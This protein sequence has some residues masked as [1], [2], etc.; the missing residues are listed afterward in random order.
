MAEKCLDSCFHRNNSKD[1]YRRRKSEIEESWLVK[2]KENLSLIKNTCSHKQNVGSSGSIVSS[3][4]KSNTLFPG[5]SLVALLTCLL[6]DLFLLFL[7]GTTASWCPF[8]ICHGLSLLGLYNLCLNFN[9]NFRDIRINSG[10]SSSSAWKFRS[11]LIIFTIVGSADQIIAR[12]AS[13]GF[14]SCFLWHTCKRNCS[15]IGHCTLW[16]RRRWTLNSLTIKFEMSANGSTFLISERNLYFDWIISVISVVKWIFS[17]HV[18][19]MFMSC[20]WIFIHIFDF[21]WSPFGRFFSWG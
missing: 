13:T 20:W 9:G 5:S 16:D 18:S 21:F 3:C 17:S 1:T 10:I 2:F 6:A 15:L 4:W 14:K 7:L 11:T 19:C 8:R 12:N